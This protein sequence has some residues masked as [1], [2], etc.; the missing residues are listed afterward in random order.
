MTQGAV[1]SLRRVQIGLEDPAGTEVDA[2]ARLVG[3]G[4]LITQAAVL[5][6]ERDFGTL[7]GAVEAPTLV[8]KGAMLDFAT[9]LSIEQLL[10][11]LY[12]MDEVAGASGNGAP[13]TYTFDSPDTTD[14]DGATFTL[15]GEAIDASAAIEQ[16]TATY[17]LVD[18]LG[19][20]VAF[21]ETWTEH[22]AKWIARSIAAKAMTADPGLP[23]RTKVP[24]GLWTVKLADTQAGLAGAS[25]IVGAIN[26]FDVGLITP[27]GVKR[28]L[29]GSDG[30]G[31]L[32]HAGRAL[33]PSVMTISLASDLIAAI[34][35]E[36]VNFEAGTA[37]FIR[38]K[39]TVDANNAVQIDM[40]GHILEPPGQGDE[41]G[42]ETRD[43]TY[44]S[45]RD[46]TWGQAWQIVVT[47]ALATL[48]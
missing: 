36:R 1:T 8:A 13:Y 3:D 28:R 7:A 29:G 33:R 22:T 16:F 21:G 11:A 19:I 12:T 42:Q 46:A 10:Y 5:R 31:D 41:S 43:L 48:P 6:P 4:H 30:T 37:R 27:Y 14:P 47:S 20:S 2:T 45:F 26:S 32:E 24:S 34:E 40:A 39:A 17:G 23:T 44:T 18:E 9:E 25:E 15:E 35:A 38:L